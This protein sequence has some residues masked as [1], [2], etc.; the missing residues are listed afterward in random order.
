MYHTLLGLLGSEGR[1]GD[2]LKAILVKLHVL[3]PVRVKS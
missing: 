3:K 1:L 2:W